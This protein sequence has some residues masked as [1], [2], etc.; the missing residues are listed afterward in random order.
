[1]QAGG[2]VWDYMAL[3]TISLCLQESGAVKVGDQEEV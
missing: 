3:L 2:I 1:M